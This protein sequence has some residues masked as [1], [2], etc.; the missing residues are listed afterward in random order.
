MNHLGQGFNCTV[1]GFQEQHPCSHCARRDALL[2]DNGFRMGIEKG[3][4]MGWNDGVEAAAQA[5]WPGDPEGADVYIPERRECAADVRK[6]L[7]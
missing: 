5:C 7:K 2:V 3:H 6:L 1:H 4:L